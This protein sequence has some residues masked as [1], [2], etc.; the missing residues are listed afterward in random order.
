MRYDRQLLLAGAKRNAVLALSEVHA[1]GRDSYGDGDY[2]CIYGLRPADWYARGIRLLGRTAV[3]CTRDELAYRIGKDVAA[4]AAGAA[5]PV[6]P[7]LIDPFAGS[8]NTLYWMARHLSV[9]RGIGFELDPS[10]FALTRA[11]LAALGLPLDVFHSDF[12]AGLQHVEPTENQ[13][14]VAFIAPPWG[15]ALSPVSG[16]DLRLTSPPI[17]EI[18]EWLSRRFGRNR[19]LF[20]I[21]VYEALNQE[22]LKEL[23]ALLDWSALKL[24][25]LNAPGQNHGVLLGTVRWK[26]PTVMRPKEGESHD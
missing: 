23:T 11:N 21:Q 10:V 15:D 19:L 16:L 17:A 26:P 25:D 1:Y 12:R 18:I 4:V 20:V 6:P 7:L 3:E 22:S 13:L 24:Y 2:V 9:E 14:V 5:S 8:G